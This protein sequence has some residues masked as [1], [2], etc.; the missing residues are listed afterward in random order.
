MVVAINTGS[1]P[2]GTVEL[3]ARVRE[4]REERGFSLRELSDECHGRPSRTQLHEV[5]RGNRSL[6]GD[7]LA[8][9]AA[10]LGADAD[11]LLQLGGT[12][13]EDLVR[14]L[15]GGPLSGAVRHGRLVPRA[16]D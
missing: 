13:S 10:A 15:L 9:V 4:L 1:R 12:V 7:L 5:E 3:G 8:R 14:E 2:R 16:H 11:E 6:S